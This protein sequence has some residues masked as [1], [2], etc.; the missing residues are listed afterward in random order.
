MDENWG[1]NKEGDM[2]EVRVIEKDSPVNADDHMDRDMDKGNG[3]N[4]NCR[5]GSKTAGNWLVGTSGRCR[6]SRCITALLQE[7]VQVHTPWFVS[8]WMSVT[9]ETGIAGG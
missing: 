3:M 4:R 6:R 5:Q 8:P 2:E 9:T 7:Q 1:R